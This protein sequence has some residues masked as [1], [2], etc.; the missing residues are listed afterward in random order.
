[1][2]AWLECTAIAPGSCR[3]HGQS[4]CPAFSALGRC[5]HAPLEF[6][7]GLFGQ[8]E[9]ER[10]GRIVQL[11]RYRASHVRCRDKAGN[12]ERIDLVHRGI[13]GVGHLQAKW[14]I[15][16]EAPGEQ[17]DLQGQPFV[18]PSGELLDNMLRALKLTRS[19]ASMVR[20]VEAGESMTPF[21]GSG[22]GAG[23]R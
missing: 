16:G 1:M 21:G 20:V 17:E 2:S 8:R 6:G 3:H 14:M 9:I 18:G 4:C 5:R 23:V 12:A 15:V 19:P 13:V 10:P 11:P 22:M 7:P